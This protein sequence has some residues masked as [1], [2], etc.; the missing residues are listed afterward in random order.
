MADAG[1]IRLMTYNI[2]ECKGWV[3]PDSA[4]ETNAIAE[5][6]AVIRRANPDVACLQEV[7]LPPKGREDADHAKRLAEATGLKPCFAVANTSPSGWKWGPAILSRK[8]PQ[9]TRTVPFPKTTCGP[10]RVA[11]IAE[12][13][14]CVV[15][16]TH[17]GLVAPDCEEEARILSAELAKEAKPVFLCGDLNSK[18]DSTAIAILKER[19]VVLTDVE[20]KTCP[21]DAPDVCIDY[22]LVDCR[23][24]DGFRVLKR[25]LG[26]S[27]TASDHLSWT[28]TVEI[29]GSGEV[30][31]DQK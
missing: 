5:V 29:P 30:K 9:S 26:E 13:D 6:A 1:E 31:G 15:C 25:E 19:F 14:D 3:T 4:S 10:R 24:A 18:P 28:V 22:I 27:R 20:K 11:L 8:V 21:A 17:F 2:R 12:F 23:H 16:S 7:D